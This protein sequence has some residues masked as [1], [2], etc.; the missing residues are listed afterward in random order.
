VSTARNSAVASGW[1]SR[2][3]EA[4]STDMGSG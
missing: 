4:R 3:A 1:E 2:S